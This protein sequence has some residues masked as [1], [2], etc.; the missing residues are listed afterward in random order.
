MRKRSLRGRSLTW[1]G[2]EE[3]KELV[4]GWRP[5]RVSRPVSQN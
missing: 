1:K 5:R 3:R 2:R 4:E